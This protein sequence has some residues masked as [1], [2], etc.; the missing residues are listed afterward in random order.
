MGAASAGAR[1]ITNAEKAIR[2]TATMRVCIV[3]LL[4]C[5]PGK[6]RRHPKVKEATPGL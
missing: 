3:D 5:G 2:E 4:R 1:C 6:M